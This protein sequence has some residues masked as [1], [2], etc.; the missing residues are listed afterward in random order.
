MSNFDHCSSYR[1]SVEELT[2]LHVIRYD[3]EKDLLPLVLSNCQYSM[4]RGHETLSEYDLPR[5]QQHIITRFLQG[6][7]FITR[8]GVPTLVNTHER[9]YETI[10][11]AVKGKVPQ[12]PLSSLTRN[13]VSRELDSYSEVCEAH[14]TLELLLGFLSMTGGSPMMPLVTY[15]QDTLRMANQTDP[16]ILKALGRC[17]LKHCASLWQLLMSLKSERMLHLKRVKEEKR[18]LKSFVSKG[19]VHKWLLE[20]H[21]FLLG[22]EYCRSLLFHPSVKE[23]VAAYMDRKEV[24]VPIDVE[25]AF[26]DS[27]QLS[28]IVEAWKYA[29][30]AKQEWMM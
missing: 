1:V 7:P 11:K 2:E 17:C 23:A 10:F 15:L 6:K 18:Q 24:D 14:K 4:E 22:P 21:E 20:M 27:I 3:V 8:T 5:I 12:E 26:P 9:D 30:T 29:V 25:A 19:N 28:Q 16:H 13:A